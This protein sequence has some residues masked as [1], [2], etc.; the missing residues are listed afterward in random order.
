MGRLRSEEKKNGLT[1]CPR[2]RDL[3]AVK[4]RAWGTLTG[5]YASP[6]LQEESGL[7]ASEPSRWGDASRRAI[8]LDERPIVPTK[9]TEVEMSNVKE[10][11][12]EVIQSQPE[13]S[14]YEEIMREL[15]FERMVA[16]GLED[17][18]HGRVVSNDEMER[19]IRTWQK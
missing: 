17:S 11:M 14:T 3:A 7:T 13:D 15:A 12:T 10:K 5:G 8:G 16:R 19:R 9:H 4:G 6:L 1:E 2:R 18:R